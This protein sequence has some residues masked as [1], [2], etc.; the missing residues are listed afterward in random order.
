MEEIS[1][2]TVLNTL[3][4]GIDVDSKKNV[5]YMMDFN[6]ICLASF[7]IL[8]DING[9]GV[10]KDKALEVLKKRDDLQF[11]TFVLESTSVYAFH[12]ATYLSNNEELLVYSPK[13]YCINPKVSSNYRK[14]F[15]DMNKDD[16]I[17]ARL[18]ADIARVGRCDK[19]NPWRGSQLVALQRLTRHRKHLSDMLAAEKNYVLNN[20]FLKFSGLLTANSQDAPFSNVF[21]TTSSFILTDF[22]STE[23]IVDTPL[24]DLVSILNEKSNKHFSNTEE[25]AKLLKQAAANSYRLDKVSSEP[26]N[27]AIASSLNCIRSFEAEIKSVDKSIMQQIKGLNDTEYM[28]L[29]SIK[30]IGKVF[31]AGIIA[32]IG[33]IDQFRNDDALA[34]YAGINWR[35]TQSGSF[36]AEDTY[37]TKTG[38][39]Y[40]RYY[41]IEAAQHV[42]WHVQEYNNFYTKKLNEVSKHK[43]ARAR[44][45]TARKLIK[46]IYAL[47][48]NRSLYKER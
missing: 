1:K 14:S 12:T 31:A 41:I 45:L 28:S 15:S 5:I 2:R 42:V 3:Y 23:E 44:V 32:E 34:K 46:L 40:L 8:N 20:I 43:E 21:G 35:K 13:V 37:M 22:M 39:S 48:S 16:A 7:S 38:N 25:T 29:T 4:V 24:E 9:V 36:E 18:L 6:Q 33:S 10:L 26:I 17:D 47:M 19:L 27:L 11:I 30:G